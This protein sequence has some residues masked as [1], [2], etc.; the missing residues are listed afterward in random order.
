MA[1]AAGMTARELFKERRDLYA[2]GPEPVFVDLPP[3]LYLAVAGAGAP[4]DAQFTSAVRAL[5]SMAYT[6]RFLARDE[7]IVD[8]KVP[9]LEAQWWA[10]N[11]EAFT[12]G[13]AQDWK[14]TLLS[15]LPDE[16][17]DDVVERARGKAAL[18]SPD[19]IDAV[20]LECIA[21][22]RCA[23]ILHRGPYDG[24]GPTIRRLH[25]FISGCGLHLHGP[26]HEI[27]LS[28]PRRTRP[29]RIR[30]ILRQPVA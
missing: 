11:P 19:G 17:D 5:Y 7:G 29:D 21:E 15:A 3:L 22:G 4:A 1:H 6:L 10:D 9:P 13:D 20:R 16:I 26:H 25:E 8:Y 12:A 23:Q 14:W 18:R 27:Y 28:D 2:A 24:E 30:T